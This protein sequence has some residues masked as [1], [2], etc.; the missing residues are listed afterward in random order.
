M[1]MIKRM[2]MVHGR[3]ITHLVL[4]V[5]NTGGIRSQAK[6]MSVTEMTTLFGVGSS[7]VVRLAKIPAMV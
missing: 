5:Q 7:Q 1:P 6:I 4:L 2:D 3:W